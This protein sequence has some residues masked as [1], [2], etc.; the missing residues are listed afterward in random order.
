MDTQLLKAAAGSVV[1]HAATV[2]AG[3]L[4][5]QGYITEGMQAEIIG[6][7]MAAGVVGWS[8]IEKRL[9]RRALEA[10]RNGH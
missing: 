9:S 3:W 10:A 2:L 7:A 1:R 6:L 4:L 8:L 5:A